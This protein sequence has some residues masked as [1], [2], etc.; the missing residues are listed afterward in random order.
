MAA[1][2]LDVDGHIDGPQNVFQ[3]AT[4]AM[5]AGRPVSEFIGGGIAA[6]TIRASDRLCV[7]IKSKHD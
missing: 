2:P 7:G 5:T 3:E 4:R 6:C 1:D